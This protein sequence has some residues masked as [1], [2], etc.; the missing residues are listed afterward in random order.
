MIAEE[1]ETELELKP[2]KLLDF[3]NGSDAASYFATI[4]KVAKTV[5]SIPPS[6]A[7]LE[8][9]FSV[10]SIILSRRRDSLDG[11]NV[12]MMMTCHALQNE[13]ICA[14]VPVIDKDKVANHIP[15]RF[16]PSEESEF[17]DL[18]WGNKASEALMDLLDRD[19]PDIADANDEDASVDM[20][21]SPEA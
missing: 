21:A 19:V 17:D 1:L 5:L 18:F 8:R 16:S 6:R 10:A 9:D 4:A 15:G 7:V 11:G 2:S 13:L 20:P 3:W 14:S 12:E